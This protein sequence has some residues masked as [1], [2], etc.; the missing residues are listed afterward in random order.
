MQVFIL[1]IILLI[2][3]NYI[4]VYFKLINLSFHI[5][6]LINLTSFRISLGFPSYSSLTLWLVL[7]GWLPSM[8]DDS[9]YSYHTW[10]CKLGGIEDCGVLPGLSWKGMPILVLEVL[11]LEGPSVWGSGTLGWAAHWGTWENTWNNFWADHPW[12]DHLTLLSW[13]FIG[14]SWETSFRRTLLLLLLLLSVIASTLTCW[15]LLKINFHVPWI[16]Q[17][18][19]PVSIYWRGSYL[20]VLSWIKKYH[21]SDF[22][23]VCR[24]MRQ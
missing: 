14:F 7:S 24:A 5:Y 15:H 20:P 17:N 4:G 6:E 21:I 22:S 8:Y 16:F 19:L 1:E 10:A 11:A 13:G 12:P 3:I 2:F 23:R 9:S 18:F